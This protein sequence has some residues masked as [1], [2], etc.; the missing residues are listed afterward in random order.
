MCKTVLS[1][2]L[3]SVL[4]KQPWFLDGKLTSSFRKAPHIDGSFLSKRT[5]FLPPNK[6][7]NTVFLD[8]SSDPE[9]E[10]K[11]GLDIVEALSGGEV[12]DSAARVFDTAVS[13]GVRVMY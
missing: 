11:G 7:E 9:M 13:A 3:S 12:G 4:T 1:E 8:W 6:K 2:Q 5:D 10:C